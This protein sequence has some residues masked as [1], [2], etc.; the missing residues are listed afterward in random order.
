MNQVIYKEGEAA[1]LIYLI[2]QGE[3][4]ISR[5]LVIR[6]RHPTE[7]EELIYQY[8]KK[9]SMKGNSKKKRIK[10]AILTKG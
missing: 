5:E 9:I 2:K 6:Q 8:N 1:D 10:S 7:A 4:E 3:V